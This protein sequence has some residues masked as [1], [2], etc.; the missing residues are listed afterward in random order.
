M[1]LCFLLKFRNLTNLYI[2]TF[3]KE[4]SMRSIKLCKMRPSRYCIKT[5]NTFVK[6]KKCSLHTRFIASR[7]PKVSQLY[8]QFV[9]KNKARSRLFWA[10][11]CTKVRSL[12]EWSSQKIR[13]R[14]LKRPTPWY[15]WHV[16]FRMPHKNLRK[17]YTH[18]SGGGSQQAWRIRVSTAFRLSSSYPNK[19]CNPVETKFICLTVESTGNSEVPF[20]N[21]S[22]WFFWW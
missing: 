4:Y 17:I 18:E 15:R 8:V 13:N 14:R 9:F 2:S 10:W 16:C 5:C 6:A 22:T 1:S 11:L 3:K 12:K 7:A 20:S 19:K 21:R